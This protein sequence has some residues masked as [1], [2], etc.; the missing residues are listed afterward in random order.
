[1]AF[2]HENRFERTKAT[3]QSAQYLRKGMSRAAKHLWYDYL[4]KYEPRFRRMEVIG[5]Y[6]VDFF[7]YKAH[8]AIDILT[9]LSRP[10]EEQHAK[11]LALRAYSIRILYIKDTD[12]LNNF[13]EVCA[14]IHSAVLSLTSHH[15]T[16]RQAAS[17]PQGEP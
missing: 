16:D 6:T 5:D 12:I 13:L 1:M 14:T 11:Q 3:T 7:C 10:P 9:P 17:S 4:A 2:S 8:L 15:P